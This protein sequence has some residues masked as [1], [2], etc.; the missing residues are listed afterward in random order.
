MG[1]KKKPLVQMLF[2]IEVWSFE[3]QSKSKSTVIPPSSIVFLLSIGLFG[4]VKH[5]LRGIKNNDGRI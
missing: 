1:L 4:V 5:L 2:Q 3:V